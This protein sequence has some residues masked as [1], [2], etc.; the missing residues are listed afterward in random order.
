MRGEGGYVV[1][2]PSRTQSYYQWV[3]S[4]PLAE[5]SWLIEHLTDR[6]ETVLRGVC[7][8]PGPRL[9]ED[10]RSARLQPRLANQVAA[11]RAMLGRT[12]WPPSNSR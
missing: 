7:I 8:S 10:D 12:T 2:P 11:S 4:S 1:V 5:A 3:D 9:H 6:D